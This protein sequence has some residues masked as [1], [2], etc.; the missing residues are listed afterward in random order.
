[1]QLDSAAP[2]N[3]GPRGP[4]VQLASGTL[5]NVMMFL[6]Q[7]QRRRHADVEL[8]SADS[9]TILRGRHQADSKDTVDTRF[10]KF[11]PPPR[12]VEMSTLRPQRASGAPLSPTD[13]NPDHF[14]GVIAD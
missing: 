11:F 4:L 12:R 8:A 7:T 2:A 10:P 9:D 5:A 6:L 3:A 14:E 1:V 13:V